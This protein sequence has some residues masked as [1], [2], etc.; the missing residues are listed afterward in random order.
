MTTFNQAGASRSL[1]SRWQRGFWAVAM[2]LPLALAGCATTGSDSAQAESAAPGTVSGTAVAGTPDPFESYNRSMYAFNTALDDAVLKPVATLYRDITPALA[3]DG[4]GNFFSNLSDMWS[5]VNNLAQARGEGAYYSAVRFSVNTVFGIGGLFDVA[6]EMGLPR[7]PQ[8]FGLTLGRW[9]V[10]T[11]PYLVLP[12]LG[13]STVRDTVAL[14]VDWEGVL[15]GQMS[16]VAARNS[17]TALGLV[18]KR[19]RL[20]QAGDMLDAVALD[21]YSLTRDVFLQLRSQRAQGDGMGSEDFEGDD[22]AGMLPPED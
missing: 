1:S 5:F 10:P 7:S 19:A 8:D 9:G 20:L 14:P 18:D 13:P 22:G 3:R 4:V 15:L 2:A 12:L 6:S 16:D 17:L 21:K 11:G